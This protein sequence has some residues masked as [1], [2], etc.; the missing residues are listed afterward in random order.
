MLEQLWPNSDHIP[1][2]RIHSCPVAQ[3]P[4]Q[5]KELL[6]LH[7]ILFQNMIL[8]TLT[9]MLLPKAERSGTAV[10][11]TLGF[12]APEAELCAT[13]NPADK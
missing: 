7:V 2:L 4:I 10:V 13:G 6:F 5:V 8:T 3:S 1:K 9:V 11:I 12:H